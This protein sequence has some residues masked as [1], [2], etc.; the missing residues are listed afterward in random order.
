KLSNTLANG[1]YLLNV[2]SGATNNVFH[3][4]IEQ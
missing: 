3:V 4:V 2:R 1:M